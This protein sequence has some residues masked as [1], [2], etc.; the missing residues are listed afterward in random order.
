MEKERLSELPDELLLKILSSLPMFE[1]A[2]ATR[3]IS[4]R[5]EGTWN[6][7]PDVKFDDDRKSKS[8]ETF[9]SFVYGYLLAND[10]PILERLTLKLSQYY[11][12]SD[13][14]FWVQIAVNRSVRKLKFHLSGKTLQLPCCL[15]TCKTLKKLVLHDLGI[16]VLPLWVCLPSLKTLHL[17]S[18]KFSSDKSVASLFRICPVLECLVVEQTKTDNVM[19][20]NIDVPTLTSLTIKR[21]RGKHTYVEKSHGFVIKAPLLTELNF[22][23]TISNFLVFES[24]PQVIKA[25]IEVICDQSENFI[26]SLPSIQHLTLCSLTSKTPYPKDTS[27]SS[28]K[29]LEL[30]ACSAGWADLLACMLNDAPNLRSLKLK[31]KHNFNY[32]D[33]MTLWE[34]PAVVPKCFSEHLETLEWRQYEGTEQERNVAGYILAHAACLKTATFSTGSKSKYQRIRMLGKLESMDRVSKTCQL[35]FDSLTLIPKTTC[36]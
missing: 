10:A 14:N 25:N 30:C 4:K 16:K 12:A 15:S 23:D 18:V 26:G 29:H 24:M 33:P 31:S 22:E 32:N 35:T 13:L 27:F 34:E 1:D 9:M 19:I 21:K 5:W 7:V 8:F 3:L 36:V 28:L 2:L 6:L 20:S 11:S 17:F